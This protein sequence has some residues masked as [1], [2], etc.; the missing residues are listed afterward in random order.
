MKKAILIVVLVILLALLSIGCFSE[1][2][3]VPGQEKVTSADGV[4]IRYYHDEK[5]NVGIWIYQHVIFVLP[6][7]CYI[8]EK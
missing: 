4:A 7:K 5:H 1:H 3:V 6:D 2:G 8:M